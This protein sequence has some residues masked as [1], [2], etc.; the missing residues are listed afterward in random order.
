VNTGVIDGHTEYVHEDSRPQGIILWEYR[1]NQFPQIPK[2][3]GDGIDGRCPLTC[4]DIT[5]G[6]W[7]D[8]FEP[9][10]RPYLVGDVQVLRVFSCDRCIHQT[11]PSSEWPHQAVPSSSG[12]GR[13]RSAASAPSGADRS[14]LRRAEKVSGHD[15]IR[16]EVEGPAFIRGMADTASALRAVCTAI[17]EASARHGHQPAA[18]SRAMTDLAGEG[19]YVDRCGDDW[20]TPISDAHTFGSTTLVAATDYGHCYAT[21]FSDPRRPPVFGYMVVARAALEA[22]VI[23]G[24]LN[25]PMIETEE[26]IKRVLCEMLYS[27]QEVKRLALEG[28]DK[29]ATAEATWLRVA[30]QCDWEVSKDRTGKPIIGG[31]RRPSIPAGIT[32]IM[33]GVVDEAFGKAQW[34]FLSAVEHVTWYGLQAGI[35]EGPND[36]VGLGPSVAMIGTDS[37]TVNAQSVCLLRALR[38]AGTARLTLMGWTDDVWT[39]ACQQAEAHEAALVGWLR[40]GFAAN[41]A[42]SE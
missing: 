2:T 39:D 41:L 12:E 3:A 34:S 7:L 20:P 13:R 6:H 30:E 15:R 29:S 16:E 36:D 38:H 1:G 4:L 27:T 42:D 11:G 37:R 33:G 22:C 17:A 24:W 10:R 19:R 8:R 26:R 25:D 31:A 5:G 14:S 23:S 28:D 21:L 18:A 35:V 40:S 9:I 32:E